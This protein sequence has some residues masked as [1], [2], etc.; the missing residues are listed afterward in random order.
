MIGSEL[1][2]IP[3]RC[4]LTFQGKKSTVDSQAGCESSV[5]S[6]APSRRVLLRVCSLFSCSP[7]VDQ[8]L[9]TFQRSHGI[10]TVAGSEGALPL[11]D[12]AMVSTGLLLLLLSLPPASPRKRLGWIVFEHN[13]HI[14]KIYFK[15][16][17]CNCQ[18]LSLFPSLFPLPFELFTFHLFFRSILNHPPRFPV[19]VYTNNLHQ[20]KATSQTSLLS[21]EQETIFAK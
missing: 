4:P 12:S 1:G 8:P 11:Q 5:S 13:T 19:S 21:N 9:L 7:A 20:V 15:I 6:A 3:P 10:L 18:M 17:S 16:L 14:H 2:K